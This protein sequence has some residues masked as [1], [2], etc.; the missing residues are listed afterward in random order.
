M[1]REQI[2]IDTN[3]LVYIHLEKNS[4]KSA[5]AL[6]WVKK[7]DS[8]EQGVVSTQV[9]SEFFTVMLRRIKNSG[10]SEMEAKKTAFSLMESYADTFSVLPVT[11]TEVK[12]AAAII[13]HHSLSYWD[14]LI[15]ATA[16]SNDI[17]TILTEDGPS[18]AT[19][20]KVTFLN[21]FQNQ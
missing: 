15:W 10:V 17:K 20:E 11:K 6:H 1:K 7:L 13:Q 18:G 5:Q 14:A 19:I 3:V 12:N 21:P 4:K 9:L 16:K 2:L 8:A